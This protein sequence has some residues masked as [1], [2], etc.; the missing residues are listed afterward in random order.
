MFLVVF[1][2][3]VAAGIA[4]AFGRG[5]FSTFFMVAFIGF[6]LFWV[7]CFLGA[8]FNII[9]RAVNTFF[10]AVQTFFVFWIITAIVLMAFGWA[11]Q[12]I[13][14]TRGTAL[15]VILLVVW[16]S[17]LGFALFL[18]RSENRR[19]DLFKP[20]RALSYLAPLAYSVNL[21]LVAVLFFSAATYVLVNHGFF[22]VNPI[23]GSSA[24]PLSFAF[25]YFWHFVDAVP[26]LK[27]NETFHW[28]P[29]LTYDSWR[30]G[31]TV[32]IFKMTVIAP[33]I[34]ACASYWRQSTGQAARQ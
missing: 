10:V 27:I 34:A 3:L 30:L 4:F 18:I 25:F 16:G 32:L 2:A 13:L 20:L 9:D 11:S 7:M 12:W 15:Q 8:R 29:P 17:I 31:M 23:N 22:R 6:A 26:L 24:P 19:A 14:D 5:R 28:N 1:T 21:L 33:V